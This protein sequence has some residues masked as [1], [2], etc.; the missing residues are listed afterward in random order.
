MRVLA[1]P[2]P[3]DPDLREAANRYQLL[4]PGT[5]GLALGYAVFV[6]RGH[7]ND[8]L[9][10]HEFRHVHQFEA[11][12]SLESYLTTY[13]AQLISHGYIDTPMEQ[14]AREAAEPFEQADEQNQLG[15][16]L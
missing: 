5:I 7:V 2:R 11:L 14:D 9:F 1:M 16:R 8:A 3:E 13:F 15:R 10:A 12:G 6:R 4:G